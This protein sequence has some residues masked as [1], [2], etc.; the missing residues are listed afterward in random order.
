MS[1]AIRKAKAMQRFLDEAKKQQAVVL[2]KERYAVRAVWHEGGKHF[3]AIALD[4]QGN[5]WLCC[6]CGTAELALSKAKS[7]SETTWLRA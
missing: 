3:D 6:L 2:E 1:G 4:H 5:A 7:F